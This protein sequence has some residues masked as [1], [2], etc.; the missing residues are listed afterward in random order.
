MKRLISLVGTLLIGVTALA[1]GPADALRFAQFNY[2]GSAR[3]LAMG[4]AFTA[5]GGDIGALAINPASSAVYR[6]GE[7]LLSLGYN[8]ASMSTTCSDDLLNSPYSGRMGRFNMPSAGAIA[9]METGNTRGLF[10]FSFGFA[11]NRIASFNTLGRQMYKKLYVYQGAEHN[12]QA[13][14]PELLTF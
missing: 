2:E 1:Q 7:A 5:L 10:N 13:Q 9:S 4:N 6:Y 12:H 8:N 3:S 11:A 14:K